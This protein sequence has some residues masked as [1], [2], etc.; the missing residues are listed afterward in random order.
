MY[1]HMYTDSMRTIICQKQFR[2]KT[3]YQ[4]HW[5]LWQICKYQINLITLVIQTASHAI[6]IKFK[7][8]YII[9]V[10]TRI[11]TANH[12]CIIRFKMTNMVPRGYK[13]KSYHVN[14]WLKFLSDY[15]QDCHKWGLVKK[16]S[17]LWLHCN[18]KGKSS[19]SLSPPAIHFK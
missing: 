1:K 2:K 19:A 4:Y 18:T 10:K 3:Q 8:I 6:N 15:N 7:F 17:I 11:I 16:I 12:S 9:P 5:R 13:Y 14:A